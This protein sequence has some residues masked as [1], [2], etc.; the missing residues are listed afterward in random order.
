M[1][2]SKSI[3]TTNSTTTK[4][5][6]GVFS[7][8]STKTTSKESTI[9]IN[10]IKTISVSNITSNFT[11]GST[12]TKTPPIS[13]TTIKST[14]VNSISFVTS[15][16]TINRKPTVKK[17][18]TSIAYFNTSKSNSKKIINTTKI[19]TA[20]TN[21]TSSALNYGSKSSLTTTNTIF[22]LNSK[23]TSISNK[24]L[25]LNISS[26][27]ITT[28]S[29][30]KS[31]LQNTSSFTTTIINNANHTFSKTQPTRIK[32]N[33]S[34]TATSSTKSS[35]K[36]IF[37]NSIQLNAVIKNLS[38]RQTTASSSALKWSIRFVNSTVTEEENKIFF[39]KTTKKFKSRLTRN[40][41]RGVECT[42]FDPKFCSFFASRPEFCVEKY[43]A[44]GQPMTLSCA[45]SCKTCAKRKL[46]RSADSVCKDY[47]VAICSDLA[48]PKYC[49]N[50]FYANGVPMPIACCKSCNKGNFLNTN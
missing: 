33:K 16:I 13:N 5:S 17:A 9:A 3:F 44:N 24:K 35:M 2:S 37:K 43:F 22:R 30:L 21:F 11:T 6:I 8:K 27:A 49:N 15:T 31:T 32:F 39:S 25:F 38:T 50:S 29:A 12:T 34:T 36:D 42:D 41:S 28:T 19:R 1:T 23:F 47:N 26:N 18:D 4:T 20:T 14:T 7:T 45:V 48:K 10:G 46:N 40:S